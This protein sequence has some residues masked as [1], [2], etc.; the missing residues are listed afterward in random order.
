MPSSLLLLLAPNN[1][2]SQIC[3]SIYLSISTCSKQVAR[4][5][6]GFFDYSRATYS[7]GMWQ[8]V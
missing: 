1:N 4:T 6:L 7:R 5:N 3:L 2:N 8:T